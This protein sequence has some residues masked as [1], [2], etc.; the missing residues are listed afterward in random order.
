MNLKRNFKNF[1]T[2]T[3]KAEGGFTL[4]ELIV[5][6]A[7][8]AILAGVA[9]PAYSGYIEK[10][11]EAAD[12][13][14]LAALNTA[15]ASACAINGES[16]IGQ[17]PTATIDGNGKVTVTV[18]NNKDIEDAVKTFYDGGV[19]K[20]FDTLGYNSAEGIFKGNTVAQ[21]I[22]A[23]KDA[24]FAADSSFAD[25]DGTVMQT[26]LGSFDQI[27]GYFKA[28]TQLGNV[29]A[30]ELMPN[31]SAELAAA[32]GI[33]DM[34]NGLNGAMNMTDA[35]MEAY[36]TE[37]GIPEEQWADYKATM[38]GNAAVLHFAGS[39]A[40]RTPEELQSKLSDFMTLMNAAQNDALTD[41]EVLAYYKSTLSA[42]N[43]AEFERINSEQEQL[44]RA[45]QF[46][47]ESGVSL[48]DLKLTGEQ[49]AAMA[50]AAKENNISNAIDVGTLGS[51]YALAAG[52]YNSEHYTGSPEDVPNFSEFGS[53]MSAVEQQG[54]WDY[55]NNNATADLEAYV[56]FMGY[57]SSGDV[58]LSDPGAFSGEYEDI[59]KAL[60]FTK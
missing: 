51:M 17:S 45:Q 38:K 23:L 58:D 15:F 16:H 40:G 10:A 32:M 24:W 36:L 29:S 48:G 25:D 54:F 13:Q 50:K 37:K 7:I 18:A 59:A 2:L 41:A 53:V 43:L 14:Q 11:N 52:Y 26:L 60:G 4:V 3:R 8:L 57:I 31:V 28:F 56:S 1:F 33:T 55:Y 22:Q 9:V 12:Q 5:V 46:R 19:F 30:E 44:A 27:G 35:E 39:S 20:Y 34:L 42:E 6:I 49:V 21:L 47:Q